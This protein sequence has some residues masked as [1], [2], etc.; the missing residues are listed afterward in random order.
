MTQCTQNCRSSRRNLESNAL[1]T[2]AL[3]VPI[4]QQPLLRLQLLQPLLLLLSHLIIIL[5]NELQEPPTQIS[6]LLR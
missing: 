1:F 6:F 5:R 4:L 3:V 2:A